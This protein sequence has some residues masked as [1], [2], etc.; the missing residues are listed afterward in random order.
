M[1]IFACKERMAGERRAPVTP[2][3]VSKLVKLGAGIEVEEGLGDAISFRDA[4]YEAAGATIGRDRERCFREADLV[5]RVR[6]PTTDEAGLLKPGALQISFLDPFNQRPLV[7]Q[8]AAG[9]VTAI[10]MEMIPRTTV[11]Q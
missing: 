5:L 1:R 3:S 6:P 10:S 9:Q 2:A 7:E 8:L 11:A 4:D